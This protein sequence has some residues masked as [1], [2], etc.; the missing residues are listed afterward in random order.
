MDVEWAEISYLWG[1]ERVCV[2]VYI[3]SGVSIYSHGDPAQ[4]GQTP[5]TATYCQMVGG[6]SYDSAAQ[7]LVLFIK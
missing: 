3:L 6:G 5:N 4:N 2:C 1:Q 7:T